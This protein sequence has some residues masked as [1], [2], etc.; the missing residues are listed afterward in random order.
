MVKRG[1]V[2]VPFCQVGFRR[3]VLAHGICGLRELLN[4]NRDGYSL[5]VAAFVYVLF[6]SLSCIARKLHQVWFQA[7]MACQLLKRN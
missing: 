2:F 3:I 7:G 1:K 4:I 5:V 6:A